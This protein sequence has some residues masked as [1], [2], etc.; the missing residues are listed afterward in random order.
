[1]WTRIS[2]FDRMFGAM[3][4]LRSQVDRMFTDFD[5][6]YGNEYGWAV[7][8]GMPRTNLHD[9]GNQLE[10]LAEVPG[11]S[12]D[13]LNIK[14]QGNYLEISGT[15][16]TDAPEKYKVHRVEREAVS[17]TRSFTLPADINTEKVE[18]SLKNGILSLKLPKSEAA[19]PKMITIN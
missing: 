11:M 16:K 15:R 9:A 3:D 7:R 8:G 18:A 14:I 10:L 2:D 12:K 4:L 5:R 19:K 6:V 1:M 13:D 17:F